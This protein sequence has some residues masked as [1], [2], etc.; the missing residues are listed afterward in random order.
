MTRFS[1]IPAALAAAAVLL[2]GSGCQDTVNT[3]ENTAKSMRLDPVEA[4]C[5][6][7]DNFCRDRLRPLGVN[8]TVTPEGF[9]RV[10]IAIRSERYGF[11]PELWS[12]FMGDNPYHVS[13]RFEWLDANGMLVRT[14]A[15]AWR[16]EI[17][18]PGEVRY[19][20]STA[21]NA[22]CRD[23]VFSVKENSASN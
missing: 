12:W 2:A 16:N 1:L 17:F 22:N 6:V 20:Q 4:R 7:T 14:A 10:Q 5:F 8:R 18:L 3:A 9:M 23:F 13:Y 19:L 15:G 21:P 11:W